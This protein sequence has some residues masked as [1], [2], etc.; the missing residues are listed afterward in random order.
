MD[1]YFIAIYFFVYGFLGWCTEVAFAACKEHRFINRGFLNGPFCPIYGFGVSLV[2]IFLTPYRSNLILLYIASIILVTLLEGITGW[3]MDKIFHNKWWDYSNMPLNIGGYVCLP[4]SVIWGIACVAIMNLIHP[5]IHHV[6][7]L[8]PHT[9]GIVLI[10]LFGILLIID[11]GVTTSAIFKF[12]KQLEHMEKIASELHELSN[13]LGEN[14]YS[15]TVRALE[16]ADDLQEK[17]RDAVVD[18]HEKQQDAADNIHARTEELKQRYTEL[19]QH[20]NELKQHT[21]RITRR[22]LRAFPALE[23]R[24]HK[25]HLIAIR[26]H[27]RER[28]KNNI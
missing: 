17:A 27:L 24:R 12:N 22:L 2:I 3:A 25:D 4:F 21:G 8:M 7:T 26:Q 19:K 13:Q 9:L 16:A 10:V 1:F 5:L 15:T 20:Y 11:T 18:F 23:S 6:L 14:I 28:L